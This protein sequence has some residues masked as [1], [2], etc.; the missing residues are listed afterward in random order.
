MLVS[1]L[2]LLKP[3]FAE[4]QTLFSGDLEGDY[5]LQDVDCT[6]YCN[7]LKFTLQNLF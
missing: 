6:L 4:L 2:G 3:P 7:V 1:Q 5:F